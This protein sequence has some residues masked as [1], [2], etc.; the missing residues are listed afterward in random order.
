MAAKKK[1]KSRSTKTQPAAAAK[2]KVKAKPAKATAKA[3]PKPKPKA[4]AK[5]KAAPKAKPKAAPKA[6]PKAAP[7]AKAKATPKVSVPISR[8]DG[9][10]HLNPKYAAELRQK[11]R[12]SR[13]D[14]GADDRAFLKSKSRSKDVLAEELG[15]EAVS[16]MTSGEAQ[17]DRFLDLEVDEE[18]GGPFVRTTGREEFALGT[19]KSNPRRASREPFPK[20]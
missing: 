20:T 3:A 13:D 18:R 19:D 8:R 1:T 17:G 9:T 12:E 14:G 7:K 10:G 6:K 5:P 4:K 2:A 16:A 11:S 15:E